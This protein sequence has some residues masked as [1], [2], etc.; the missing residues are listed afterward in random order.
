ME[1]QFDLVSVLKAN[2]IP[3]ILGA[4]GLILVSVGAFALLSQKESS[5]TLEF[6]ASSNSPQ[7]STSGAVASKIVVDIQ[8]AVIKPGIYSLPQGSRIHDL[9]VASGGLSGEADRDWA[10][11][12]LNL[13]MK[14]S[15]GQKIYIHRVG[16][17]ILD[18]AS[19]STISTTDASALININSASLKEL[20]TLPGIGPV[21]A[22]K[23][24]DQRPFASISD[25]LSKKTVSSSVF[26]K[27]KDKITA[28]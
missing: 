2:L 12:N 17:Q 14:L 3:L 18:G 19:T 13:A 6:E 9:V 28:N 22:Q 21:T 24:L 11:K 7:A 10:S 4:L 25:L 23:I 20:D 1:Q 15:D 5:N 16:E 26:E 8:G 27:I